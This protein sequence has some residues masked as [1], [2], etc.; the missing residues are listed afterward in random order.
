MAESDQ[1]AQF[2]QEF[3]DRVRAARIATGMKQWQVAEAL[4]IPQDKYKQYEVQSLLPHYL[5][6]RFCIIC[7]VEPEWL[8][9]GKGQKPLKPPH[10]VE[11]E[12]KPEVPKPKRTRRPR[13]A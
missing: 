9:T 10:V 3:I 4:S 2:K 5:I 1:E 8:I 7:R 6:G 11:S 12:D 13:A